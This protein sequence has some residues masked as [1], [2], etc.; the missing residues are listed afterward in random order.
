MQQFSIKQRAAAYHSPTLQVTEV[1]LRSTNCRHPA[2]MQYNIHIDLTPGWFLLFN[3]SVP[4][5]IWIHVQSDL[6]AI[7]TGVATASRK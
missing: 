6:I 2:S 1:S 5:K 4:L 3:L 7:S